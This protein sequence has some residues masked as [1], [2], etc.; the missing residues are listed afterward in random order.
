MGGV[1]SGERLVQEFASKNLVAILVGHIFNEVQQNNGTVP[2][3]QPSRLMR[4][5]MIRMVS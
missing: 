1:Y 2:P 5:K 3:R 4:K